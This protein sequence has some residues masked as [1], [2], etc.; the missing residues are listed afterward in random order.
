[1]TILRGR[2]SL[3]LAA[4]RDAEATED[5]GCWTLRRPK[6]PGKR[7][8][9]NRIHSLQDDVSWENSSSTSGRTAASFLTLPR[10]KRNNLVAAWLHKYA[11]DRHTHTHEHACVL[12][13]SSLSP[14]RKILRSEG[15]VAS[16]SWAC[17]G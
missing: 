7:W 2:R 10:G 4:E 17:P 13:L 16:V 1:M 3:P 15:I 14:L 6:T 9:R 11:F 5:V 12:Y 8:Q